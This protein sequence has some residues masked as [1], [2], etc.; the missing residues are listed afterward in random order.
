[1]IQ[2]ELPRRLL[3]GFCVLQSSAFLLALTCY[4]YRARELL[5]CWLFFCSLFAG[6]ALIL[7][8]IVMVY[9]SAL[10][11]ANWVRV[12][13]AGI[14][15]LAAFLAELPQEAILP[16]PRIPAAVAVESPLGPNT[17]VNALDAPSCLLIEVSLAIESGV[18]K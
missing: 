11:L 15:E 18:P 1:M 5:V 12:V 17:T 9:Y 7:L 14:P 13:Y 3:A 4:S 16:G 6:L 10:H 2:R 8:A